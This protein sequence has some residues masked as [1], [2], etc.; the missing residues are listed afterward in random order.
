MKL[1]IVKLTYVVWLLI[2]VS[3]TSSTGSQITINP[4]TTPLKWSA[5]GK[6]IL[7]GHYWYFDIDKQIFKKIRPTLHEQQPEALWYILRDPDNQMFA[8]F[9]FSQT[10][11]LARNGSSDYT[12]IT[13]PDWL[14]K[15]EQQQDAVQNTAFFLNRNT[16]AV[17]QYRLYS[18]QKPVCGMYDVVKRVWTHNE[19]NACIEAEF[20][21]ISK[22]EHLSGQQ[23]LVYS[24]VE[25]VEGID[26]VTLAVNNNNSISQTTVANLITGT[27][28]PQQVKVLD[29]QTAYFISSCTIVSGTIPYCEDR[30]DPEKD[31]WRLYKWNFH[32]K[33]LTLAN[34][35]L[36]IGSVFSPVTMHYAWI[37]GIENK[38]LCIKK[39]ND[40]SKQTCIP[41]PPN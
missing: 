41:L 37:T 13:I 5:D 22:V 1:L 7:V 8:W 10:L 17:Q 39:F 24:G 15:T 4:W 14:S 2:I 30:H 32:N 3:C 18:E 23:Y 31:L 21:R 34:S 12:N 11:L 27:A 26:L 6:S 20:S 19:N 25:G 33:K 38:E 35:K 40:K 29:E 36:P 9:N 28:S 16:V